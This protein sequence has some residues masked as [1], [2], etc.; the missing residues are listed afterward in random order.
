MQFRNSPLH[1]PGLA[2]KE[3]FVSL[4]MILSSRDGV[5]RSESTFFRTRA[6]VEFIHGLRHGLVESLRKYPTMAR[7]F[8]TKKKSLESRE[9]P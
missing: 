9:C 5:V 7:I 2:R 4:R 8:S 6:W 1:Y 3:G